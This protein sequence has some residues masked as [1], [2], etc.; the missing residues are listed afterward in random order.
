MD[1]PLVHDGVD[2]W[3]LAA[4]A[5]ELDLN[6]RYAYLLWFRDFAG[7]SLVA[8]SSTGV[9]GFVTGYRKPED[10]TTLVVWQ[11]A[12]RAPCRRTGLARAMLHEL[13]A[14]TAGVEYVEASVTPGNRGSAALFARFAADRSAPLHRSE[15]FSPSLL[16]DGH[17]AEILFRIGPVVPMP[18]TVVVDENGR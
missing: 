8:R 6:S 11:V 2:C 18:S 17:E 15:L 5:H 13:H 9:V 3:T 7:T 4:T 1:R 12:V 14:R 16:D 10:R